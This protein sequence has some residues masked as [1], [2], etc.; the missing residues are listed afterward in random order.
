MA[1]ILKNKKYK[2]VHG[3]EVKFMK[4]I[5][6][7]EEIYLKLRLKFLK[8][9]E[10]YSKFFHVIHERYFIGT[11]YDKYGSDKINYKYYFESELIPQNNLVLYRG[12]DCDSKLVSAMMSYI[13]THDDKIEIDHFVKY[14]EIQKDVII[15]KYSYVETHLSYMINYSLV[16][17]LKKNNVDNFIDSRI[18]SKFIHRKNLENDMSF[19]DFC[20]KVFDDLYYRNRNKNKR[21]IDNI[22]ALTDNSFDS[23]VGPFSL[24]N[25]E[26]DSVIINKEILENNTTYDTNE[27]LTELL[28]YIKE[29]DSECDTGLKIYGVKELY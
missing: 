13:D 24:S 10:K 28:R 4:C 26:I 5:E 27:S 1:Q 3:A 20:E 19:E 8:E 18:L 9:K 16:P 25:E 7:S 22:L 11:V 21:S 17:F 14:V 2:M 15:K 29:I 23:P 6:I 12:V